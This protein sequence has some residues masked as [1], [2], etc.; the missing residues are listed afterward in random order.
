ML[1]LRF[2]RRGPSCTH[3]CAAQCRGDLSL[4]ACS[5]VAL[6][7]VATS[8]RLEPQLGVAALEPKLGSQVCDCCQVLALVPSGC[9]HGHVEERRGGAVAKANF[10]PKQLLRWLS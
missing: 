6:G 1:R 8:G 7:I 3:G 4:M 10:D 2:P 5:A 9:V